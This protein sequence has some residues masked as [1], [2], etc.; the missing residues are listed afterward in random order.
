MIPDLNKKQIFTLVVAV[1]LVSSVFA[2]MVTFQY[3]LRM[4]LDKKETIVRQIIT[5]GKDKEIT[6]RILRQDELIVGVVESPAMLTTLV[7]CR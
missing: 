7:T 6:E 2:S 1:S 5:G 4:A 3:I